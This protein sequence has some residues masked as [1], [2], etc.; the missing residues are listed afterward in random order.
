MNFGKVV[1]TRLPNESANRDTILTRDLIAPHGGLSEPVDRMV[2]ETERRDFAAKADKLPAL[3]I[4][5]ADLSTL[6]R[7]GDGGLSPLV[8]PMN[9]ETFDRVLD[10]EHIVHNGKKYAW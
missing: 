8:G 6:Y 1:K 9:R 2:P 3:R 7:F 5:D 4:S 10:A